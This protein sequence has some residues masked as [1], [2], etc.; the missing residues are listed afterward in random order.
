MGV[1]DPTV[2]PQGPLERYGSAALTGAASSIPFTPFAGP[3]ALAAGAGGGLAA[4]AASDLFPGSVL[5]PIA[6]GV[7]GGMGVNSLRSWIAGDRVEG[8]AKQLGQATTHQQAGEALQENAR[9]WLTHILPAKVS[10]AWA[11]VDAAVAPGT[12]TPLANFDSTVRSMSRQGGALKPLLDAIG[13]TLPDKLKKIIDTKTLMGLGIAPTW[14]EAQ[15]LRNTIGDAMANPKVLRDTSEKQLAALY[16]S[17]TKDMKSAAAGQGAGDLFDQANA[18]SSRLY[19]IASGPMARIVKS[20]KPTSADPTPES[21][22][23]RLLSAGKTGGTDLQ[24]LREQMP[25]AVDNLAAAHLRAE[26]TGWMKLSPEAK[27]ALLVSPE[28]RR[29]VDSAMEVKMGQAPT[30]DLDMKKLHHL[31]QMAVG[32]EAGYH[33]AEHLL[34]SGLGLG[35]NPLV[36]L[37][38]AALGAAIPPTI[39]AGKYVLRNPNLLQ[40]PAAGGTAGNALTLQPGQQQP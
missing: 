30:H 37:A 13:P 4:Q 23:K 7:A 2:K 16:A 3:M 27:E 22:A 36:P 17:L 1:Y 25:W 35:D 5:A 38:A 39:R 11:P 24:T 34:A 21:V 29:L 28:H 31:A 14:E 15:Q 19:N 12:G 33:G 32:G 18:E 26:G 8:L 40:L 6:A 10:N 9:D 20:A